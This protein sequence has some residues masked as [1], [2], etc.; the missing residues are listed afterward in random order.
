MFTNV[1]G[2]ILRIMNAQPTT[3][4]EKAGIE[5]SVLRSLR[6]LH[7]DRLL[8]H[9][10]FRIRYHLDGNWETSLGEPLKRFELGLVM[11]QM[12]HHVDLLN[13]HPELIMPI[14]LP[15]WPMGGCKFTS[16]QML[17]SD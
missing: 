6:Q 14:T 7:L 10:K 13:I 11:E 4:L 1:T 5:P 17:G 2:E 8:R 16:Y 3:N 15:Q 12:D 9:L